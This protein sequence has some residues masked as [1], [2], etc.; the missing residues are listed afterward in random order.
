MLLY[1]GELRPMIRACFAAM[2]MYHADRVLT[3][4]VRDVL[5]RMQQLFSLADLRDWG[6]LIRVRFDADNVHLKM[7]VPATDVSAVVV[8]A[9]SRTLN[10]QSAMLAKLQY[11]VSCLRRQNLGGL[12][13]IPPSPTGKVSHAPAQPSAAASTPPPMGSLLPYVATGSE[14]KPALLELKGA[15][16]SEY[17]RNIRARGCTVDA[18]AGLADGDSDRARILLRWFNAMAT[19]D[20]KATLRP[21][22]AGQVLPDEGQR[23]EIADRLQALIVARLSD[24]WPD[25]EVPRELA[26]GALTVGALENRLRAIGKLPGDNMPDV[27]AGFAEWRKE[28]EEKQASTPNSSKKRKGV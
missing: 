5:V 13:A 4:E 11:E 10:Q 8:Q 2:C 12:A 28:H 19:D 6:E 15:E 20:E 22:Q 21:A 14:P 17:Y 18:P 9:L 25:G 27:A 7:G 23:R 26:K 16:S 1:H 3:G 24:C